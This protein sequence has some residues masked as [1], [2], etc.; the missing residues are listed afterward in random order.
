MNEFDCSLAKIRRRKT[1]DNVIRSGRGNGNNASAPSAPTQG[2]PYPFVP[3]QGGANPLAPMPSVPTQG[4]ANPLAPMPSVP[5][6]GGAY[7]SAPNQGGAYPPG[8][9]MP[10]QATP[11][12]SMYYPQTQ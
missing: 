1:R 4:G 6:Q 7:P 9:N 10:V 5:T 8:Y 11:V 12:P 2:G 3:T